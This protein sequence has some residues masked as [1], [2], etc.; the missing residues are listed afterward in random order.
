MAYGYRRKH[1]KRAELIEHCYERLRYWQTEPQKR[2]EKIEKTIA[3]LK[4]AQ[5]AEAEQYPPMEGAELVRLVKLIYIYMQ[6]QTEVGKWCFAH[7]EGF[8]I[9][10]TRACARAV[11]IIDKG[12]S[13]DAE[14]ETICKEVRDYALDV[15]GTIFN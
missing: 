2:I 4:E 11:E 9:N 3:F 12:K 7:I 1:Y 5:A 8:A 6:N 15:A 14:L 10:Q 13:E